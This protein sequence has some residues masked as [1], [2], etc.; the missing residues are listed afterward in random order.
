MAELTIKSL[1]E[2]KKLMEETRGIPSLMGCTH[3][4]NGALE[5]HK[6]KNNKNQKF[7]HECFEEILKHTIDKNRI[8]LGC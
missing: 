7:C 5:H 1:L 4:F 6:L 2:A 8:T 3:Y